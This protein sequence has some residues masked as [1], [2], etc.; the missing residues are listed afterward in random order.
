MM[1]EFLKQGFNCLLVLVGQR[2]DLIVEC[3]L[4]RILVLNEDLQLLLFVL[5]FLLVQFLKL[6]LILRVSDL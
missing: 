4:H 6:L 3:L 1:F 2:C 5:Q